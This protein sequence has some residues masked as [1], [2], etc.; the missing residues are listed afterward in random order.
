MDSVSLNAVQMIQCLPSL[1]GILSY[2]LS[3]HISNYLLLF[4]NVT[5]YLSFYL[6]VISFS[7]IKR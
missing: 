4:H 1:Q 7:T 3:I 6:S 2:F 5:S